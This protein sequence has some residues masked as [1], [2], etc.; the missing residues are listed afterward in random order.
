MF[1]VWLPGAT[2]ADSGMSN[3]KG[4]IDGIPS[5]RNSNK[6]VIMFT[7]GEPKPSKWF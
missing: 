4:V 3:A 1:G 6:V 7:D 5:D 2:Y